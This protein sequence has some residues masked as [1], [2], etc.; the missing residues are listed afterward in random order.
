MNDGG[1]VKR[2]RLRPG[3]IVFVSEE[4]VAR[5]RESLKAFGVTPEAMAKLADFKGDIT[6]GPRYPRSSKLSRRIKPIKK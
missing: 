1:H 2:V 5:A 6:I 4:A 3:K